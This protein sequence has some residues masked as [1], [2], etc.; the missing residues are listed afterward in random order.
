MASMEGK[1]I[2]ITGGA[3]GIGLAT[4]KLLAS[5]GAKLSIADVQ[6][7]LLEE[8]AAAIKATGNSDFITC[9]VDVRNPESIAAWI[10]ATLDKFGRLD[11]AANIAGVFKAFPNFSAEVEDEKNWG[12]MLDVNLTGL[13]QCMKAQLPHLKEGGSMVNAASILGLQ[14][15]VGSAGYAASKHGVIGLTRSVAKEVGKKGIRVNCIAP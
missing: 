3:S 11:C 7:N 13:M 9:Q 5:R 12:F 1:V 6:G 14:G 15:S 10:K 2:A 8:A 4:A